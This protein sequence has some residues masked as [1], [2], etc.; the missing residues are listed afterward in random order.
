MVKYGSVW[1]HGFRLAHS[2]SGDF[3]LTEASLFTLPHTYPCASKLAEDWLVTEVS[4]TGG[5]SNDARVEGLHQ[6]DSIDQKD[7]DTRC[8]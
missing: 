1:R 4:E 2:I 3:L 6:K 7:A 8:A 5:R